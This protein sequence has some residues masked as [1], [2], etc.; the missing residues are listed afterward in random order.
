MTRPSKPRSAPT[1]GVSSS[2]T[3]PCTDAEGARSG[4]IGSSAALVLTALV[5]PWRTGAHARRVSEAWAWA[6]AAFTIAVAAPL[7]ALLS[8]WTYLVGKGLLIG[9][10]EMDLGQDD[11]PPDSVRQVVIG[12]AG[13]ILVWAVL[14]ALTLLVCLAVADLLYRKD[15]H[16]FSIARR[17]TC[18]ASVWFVV[19]AVAVLAANSVRH[20]E[21]RRPAE[22]VRAYAQLRQ[23]G[24][25]GSSAVSPGPPE[26]EPLAG[27]A[28]LDLLA[29]FFPIIWSIGL[30]AAH[31]GRRRAS[32]AILILGA[33][34]LWWGL[35]IAAGR[36]LPWATVE[37]LL[38]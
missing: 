11:L 4:P 19:W 6:V 7:S 26:R 20:D 5:L 16:A 35:W 18:G 10:S 17:A 38:G 3:R 12:L 14:L 29:A 37:A 21:V 34:G 1:T 28:R 32:Q 13:S 33:V 30:P 23:Q 24:F 9:R 31:G 27:R 22:A 25:R 2:S 36:L 15:R 8:S